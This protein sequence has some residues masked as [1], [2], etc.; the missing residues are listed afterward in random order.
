MRKFVLA[1]GALAAIG[2]ALPVTSPAI[3]GDRGDRTVVIKRGHRD[4]PDIFRHRDRDRKVVIIK[5]RHHH[6]DY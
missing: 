3:A 6:D 4:H 2:I 5:R 1:L